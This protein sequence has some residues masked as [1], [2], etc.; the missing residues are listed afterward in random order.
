[1]VSTSWGR[2]RFHFPT[3]GGPFS[4]GAMPSWSF[5]RIDAVANNRDLRKR[6]WTKPQASPRPSTWISSAEIVALSRVKPST[7][8]GTVLW[9][10]W[11]SVSRGKVRR[12][13]NS[14]ER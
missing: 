12:C 1:M 5:I 11:R 3:T 2:P 7:L 10:V 4:G 8:W 6:C 14:T 9:N 13:R